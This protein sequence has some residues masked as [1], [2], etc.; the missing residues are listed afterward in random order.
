MSL[1]DRVVGLA[2][3][4]GGILLFVTGWRL[5]L[6]TS[7]LPGPGFFPLLIACAMGG[8]G[9]WL[10]LR[11]GLEERRASRRLIAMGS[12][13]PSLLLSIVAYALVLEW[14]GVL[15]IHLRPSRDSAPLGR[16]AELAYLSGHRSPGS[17]VFLDPVP[18]SSK[19]APS[20]R[21]SPSAQAGGERQPDGYPRLTAARVSFPSLTPGNLLYRLSRSADRDRDRR[22]PR[23]RPHRLHRPAP[24]G[25]GGNGHG[26][27]ADFPGGNLL[28]GDVRRVDDFHP[29]EHPGRSGL[30]GHLH[31]R[32]PDGAPGP[33]RARPW[34]SRPSD[35]SSEEPWECWPSC[36]SLPF[37]RK[38]P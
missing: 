36:S 17:S 37:L 19:S 12:V 29:G 11:P 16:K 23:P 20:R 1:V 6:G 7:K 32:L 18:G 22:S 24:P 28:R 4:L 2:A 26:L 35:L 31:R 8:L 13:R 30:R 5:D 14:T 33:S 34:A 10:L 3:L 25:T 27:L 38:R 9:I 21:D 15:V